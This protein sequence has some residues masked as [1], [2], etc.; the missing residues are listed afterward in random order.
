M[1]FKKSFL[2]FILTIF[3]TAL[4]LANGE[5]SLAAE[6]V[7]A[8]KD[9]I[10]VTQFGVTYSDPYRWMEN[11]DDNDLSVWWRSQNDYTKSLVDKA[12]FEEIKEEVRILMEGKKL[13]SNPTRRLRVREDDLSRGRMHQFAPV[14]T[15]NFGGNESPTRRYTIETLSETGSDLKIVR[16]RDNETKQYLA[17][18]FLV[19]F[20]SFFWDKDEASF[21]YVT[22]R[23]GRL[24]GSKSVIRR[25]T[26][27]TKFVNDPVLFEAPAS[28]VELFLVLCGEQ[29]FLV[30]NFVERTR[31]SSFNF[32]TGETSVLVDTFPGRSLKILDSWQNKLI[33]VDYN[34]D[35][36]PMGSLAVYDPSTKALE[37]LIPQR[38]IPL[39]IAAI[40]DNKAYVSYLRD[41]VS[42][43]YV[44]DL[45]DTRDHNGQLI[46]LPGNDGSVR[47]KDV[48]ADKKLKIDYSSYS[49]P[50]ASYTVESDR[51]LTL[52]G[53]LAEPLVDGMES[54]RVFYQLPTGQYAPIWLLKLKDTPLTPSTPVF[55]YGYGGF[56]VN[57]LPWYSPSYIPFIKRGGVVAFA[58]LPGGLEYG[59]PWH[60]LGQLQ[61]KKNVFDAF[62]ASAEYLVNQGWTSHEHIAIGGTSNGGL[63]AATAA[64]LYP[65]HFKA[66][67]PEV[68]VLDLVRFGRFTGGKWWNKEYGYEALKDDFLNMIRLSPYH[69]LSR[70]I[71][72]PHMLVITADS[73]D[74][75]VPAHSFKFAAR[76]IEYSK[77][78]GRQALLQVRRSSSHSWRSGQIPDIT[79]DQAIKWD[80]VLR[81][82]AQ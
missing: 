17:D 80:F 42:E 23:D 43:L 20:A 14:I 15:E 72:P 35:R 47:F 54:I 77:S 64:L 25:H 45:L 71:T 7:R 82:T 50:V 56:S 4:S 21:V 36:S 66:S 59:Q 70:E 1:L 74:R 19:K 46:M 44:Y 79:E 37:T 8:K 63:L 68:G 38:D 61:N 39:D 32:A 27:G 51:S 30:E 48:T 5:A 78:N 53:K 16:I 81:H 76:L 24:G 3:L 34:D 49:T 28:D 67:V 62:A 40:V 6:Q 18:S 29:G 52:D 26:L 33:F 75:V 2:Y 41:T 65:N 9:P 69:L 55:L 57:I 10:R 13:P 73:D 22:D 12:R 58:T 11:S 60:R 31:L